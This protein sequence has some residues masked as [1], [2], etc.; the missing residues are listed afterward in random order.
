M[1]LPSQEDECSII[2][3]STHAKLVWLSAALAGTDGSGISISLDNTVVT[4]S[5]FRNFN[6][7]YSAITTLLMISRLCK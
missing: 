3:T 1:L 6:Y 2:A 4:G 7:H 5:D